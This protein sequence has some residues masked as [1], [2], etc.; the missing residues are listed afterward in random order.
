[1]KKMLARLAS[2]VPEGF[3]KI[4]GGSAIAGWRSYTRDEGLLALVAA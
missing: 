1:M 4:C 2:D 3:K